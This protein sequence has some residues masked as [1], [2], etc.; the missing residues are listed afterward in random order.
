MEN[1][2][3]FKYRGKTLEELQKMTLDEFAQVL[4]SKERRKIKRGF[5]EYEKTFLKKL[6]TKKNIK[7][8][9]RSMIILPSFVGKKI[10]VH[11]GKEFIQVTIIPE[12]LGCRLGELAPTRKIGIK[13]AGSKREK[14]E[15]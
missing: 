7:T 14:E 2:R 5:T 15:K 3:Q 8:H 10:R 1:L 9:S 12:M 13:H 6:K 11:N 4:C